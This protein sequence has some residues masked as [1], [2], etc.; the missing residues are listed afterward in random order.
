MRPRFLNLVR[1]ALVSF[2]A[3][4]SAAV[5][6]VDS[7]RGPAAAAPTAAAPVRHVVV[8]SIDGMS[9]TAY[10]DPDGAGLEVPNL[11]RLV[12][13]GAAAR[14]LVGVLPSVTYPSHTTMVTAVPPREHGILA[15][16]IFD[17]SGTSNSAWYWYAEEIRVPT[18]WSAARAGGLSVGAVSWPVTV[19]APIDALVP[20]VWR[21]GSSNPADLGLQRALSTP[22]LVQA[23]ERNLGR[24]LSWPVS[25]ADRT[26][27]ALHILRTSR[28]NLLLL[29]LAEHDHFQHENGPGS[30]EAKAALE[31]DDRELGRV[32]AALAELGLA[33]QTLLVV[34]SDHGFLP[35]RSAMRPNVILARAGLLETDAAGKVSSWRAQFW[36]QG[37]TALLRLADPKDAETRDRVRALFAARQAEEGSG[38]AA[39]LDAEAIRAQGGDPE[40]TA[41]ALDA[42]S[43]FCFEGEAT[44]EWLGECDDL[45]GH[46]FSP[47]RPELRA[48]FLMA[49]PGVG[50]RSDLGTLP[51]TEVA[52]L[53]AR[54]LGFALPRP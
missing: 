37:G 21:S 6:E 2:V 17:P 24:A 31:R 10:L 16:R 4:A 9:P 48:S 50:A 42:G 25:D 1:F 28:P 36:T 46:G 53:V 30:A 8:V 20:E 33:D 11:R 14:A 5:A 45:G 12:R 19:G 40:V 51:M 54:A 43:G 7:E 3:L 39:L 47:L 29:H 32:R 23:V 44:G 13:E 49:G 26:E 15:N 18:L 38:I 52:P 27:L 34:V 41:L 22:G 35:T